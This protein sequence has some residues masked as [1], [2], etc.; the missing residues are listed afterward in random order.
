MNKN[1]TI[2]LI[3]KFINKNFHNNFIIIIINNL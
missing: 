2:I 1:K 3:K